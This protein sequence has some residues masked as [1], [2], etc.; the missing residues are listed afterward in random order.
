MREFGE[1][2][3]IIQ[4]IDPSA[5]SDFGQ[6]IKPLFGRVVIGQGLHMLTP[7]IR[8]VRYESS[9]Y[10]LQRFCFMLNEEVIKKELPDVSDDL[11]QQLLGTGDHNYLLAIPDKF[12]DP[13]T[14][15]K[16]SYQPK[17][18]RIVDEVTKRIARVDVHLN[19]D[20][21]KTKPA[22]LM[23]D[24]TRVA[25]HV[26]WELVTFPNHFRNLD[27]TEAKQRSQDSQQGAA[28]WVSIND[29]KGGFDKNERLS[30]I[31]KEGAVVIIEGEYFEIIRPLSLTVVSANYD[32]LTMEQLP[33]GS[34]MHLLK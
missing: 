19:I 17:Y 18:N 31:I 29:F 25:E 11:V 10:L 26:Q 12:K 28:N 8:A 1:T 5:D 4:E 33:D 7:G 24:H 9:L 21:L 34:T 14:Q 15:S 30:T 32:F 20:D 16:Y 22:I 23:A 3:I 6:E 2:K 27:Q 13:L